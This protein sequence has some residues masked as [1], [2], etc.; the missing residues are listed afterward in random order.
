MLRSTINVIYIYPIFVELY[1][2]GYGNENT[3]AGNTLVQCLFPPTPIYKFTD[4][5]SN[6]L[7]EDSVL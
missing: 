6:L 2:N 7:T 3:E 4:C 1:W 5:F